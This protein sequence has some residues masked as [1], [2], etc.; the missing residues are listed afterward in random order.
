MPNQPDTN[1]RPAA[2]GCHLDTELPARVDVQHLAGDD[3]RVALVLGDDLHGVRLM[4]PL[5]A[6]R[7]L[8]VELDRQL[9]YIAEEER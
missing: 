5:D 4:G 2:L 7:H 1:V 6:M 9:T 8:V 3:Q